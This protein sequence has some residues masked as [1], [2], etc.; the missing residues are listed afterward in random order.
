M[1]L[2]LWTGSSAPYADSPLH[3]SMLA[4]RLIDVAD[5]SMSDDE[6]SLRY[7]RNPFEHVE[8]VIF[9]F[10]TCCNF[11]CDHC[12]NARVPRV[13]EKNPQLLAE[14]ANTFIRMGIRRFDFVGG[15]ASLFGDGWLDV[16][17]HI[18]SRGKD[19]AISLY[20][21]GWWLEQ[22]NFQAAG[23][24]VT[25][26]YSYIE[27]MK[28][29]GVTYLTFSL[30]GQGEEHDQSRHH[31]GLYQKVLRGLAKVK[32]AGLSPRVSLLICPQW[33]DEQSISFLAEVAS[34]IYEFDL[35]T[36]VEKRA[37]RLT[38]DP[39]NSLSNFID[40]GNG[41]SDDKVQFPILDERKHVLHCRNFYRLSPSL[42][43]KANSELA[44][45]WLSQVGEGYGN[46]RETPLVEII[47]T[48]IKY[49]S[50]DFSA[51][52]IWK[53]ISLLW[54]SPCLDPPL[55]SFA[56]YGASLLSWRV[57]CMNKEFYGMISKAFN[58]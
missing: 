58:V 53:N 48:L 38:L 56:V 8:K 24:F 18:R 42:T 37:Q 54:I 29:R 39:M 35:S 51:A 45:C 41:A 32:H 33:S 26:D 5:E 27:E 11:N 16:A 3:N 4:E 22:Q 47:T 49:S 2:D 43:I 6:I 50:T 44:S 15:E 28:R 55:L 9:E 21:N 19:I 31:S 34:V 17:S 1:L 20:T 10:T 46:I 30:D 7:R 13:T 14:A 12:Y 52:A 57:R 25:D 23:Q 36:P 40:I